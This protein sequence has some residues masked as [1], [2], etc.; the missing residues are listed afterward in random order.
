MT[1]G[2]GEAPLSQCGPKGGGG[3]E[4]DEG[5][6]RVRGGLE[7]DEGGGGIMLGVS[8]RGEACY[9]TF[10]PAFFCQVDVRY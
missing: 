3:L 5:G 10:V 1:K 7:L 2:F 4:L 9:P 8:P 6:W